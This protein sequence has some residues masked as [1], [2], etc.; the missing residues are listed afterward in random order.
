MLGMAVWALLTPATPAS[1]QTVSLEPAVLQRIPPAD[2]GDGR[3]Y[4]QLR[5]VLEHD[6]AASSETIAIDL[7]EGVVVSDTDSDG[8]LFDEI[9]VV[10][11]AVDAE[12]PRFKA[13]TV[14]SESR[15]VIES[16]ERA[17]AGGELYVQFPIR[18]T[19]ASP[20]SELPS[21]SDRAYRALQFADDREQDLFAADLPLLT[22]V[23][24]ETFASVGSMG[25]VYLAAPLAAGED[26]TTT[27]RGTWF[28]SEPAVLVLSLPDL[29]FDAG[30]GS[31]NRLA[32]HGDGDDANDT[33][34]RFFFSTDALLTVNA[35]VAVEARRVSA[36]ADTVHTENEGEGRSL[37]LVT[38]DL[39]AGSYWL[40]VTA[41]VTGGIP[42][43]RSRVLVVR[44]EPVI[45]RLGPP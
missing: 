23:D 44:H 36:A 14:T 42:L 32:G 26:T 33:L 27:A 9:R 37:Q 13:A 19:V 4:Q 40:Y 35:D 21:S 10:Y 17:G 43:A 25:I 31:P 22:F 20:A 15:I 3:Y 11:R 2:I 28:P 18:S 34:Y 29:V 45:E 1:A 24:T 16:Q 5:I 12:L 38:R 30:L 8:A 7:P 6:D 41:D 39:S